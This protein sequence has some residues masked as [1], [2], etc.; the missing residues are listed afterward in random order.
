L[1]KLKLLKA[2][3]ALATDAAGTGRLT[4]GADDVFGC[5]ADNDFADRDVRAVVFAGRDVLL[6]ID[7]NFC[8]PSPTARHWATSAI[9]IQRRL[10]MGSS[11]ATRFNQPQVVS[12]INNLEVSLS[13]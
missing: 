4:T 3:L 12:I 7:S 10:G 1:L 6:G 11:I 5:G 13:S 8:V 9:A 2:L